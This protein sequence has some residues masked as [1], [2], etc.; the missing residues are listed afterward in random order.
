MTFC[1]NAKNDFDTFTARH[2][3]AMTIVENFFGSPAIL[4]ISG[5]DNAYA[6]FEGRNEYASMHDP[7]DPSTFTYHEFQ[8]FS[9]TMKTMA[10]RAPLAELD[11]QIIL[12]HNVDKKPYKWD[13]S[14]DTFELITNQGNSITK[15]M[16]YQPY[17]KTTT[18][19]P[20]ISCDPQSSPA[21]PNKFS[22]SFSSCLSAFK[23]GL[24]VP[25][26][27]QT[28][29]IKLDTGSV[30]ECSGE[31]AFSTGAKCPNGWFGKYQPE[32]KCLKMHTEPENNID[33]ARQCYREGSDLFSR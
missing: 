23:H 5:V 32:E 30:A 22:E 12:I 28:I 10:G 4:F 7:N 26:P 15:L 31:D 11:G 33:A 18:R 14:A 21:N 2:F 1:E 19:W 27:G 9:S 3:P 13:S 24:M 29:S 25:D 16:S 17:F 8:E 6:S 20:S